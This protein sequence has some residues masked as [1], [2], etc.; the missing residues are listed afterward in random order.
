MFTGK[1]CEESVKRCD[2]VQSDP[3]SGNGL[4]V[5]VIDD[6]SCLCEPG[7]VGKY[8]DLPVDDCIGMLYYKIDLSIVKYST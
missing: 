7:W 5:D 2:A 4:C 6:V 3:C 8:C 1:Q